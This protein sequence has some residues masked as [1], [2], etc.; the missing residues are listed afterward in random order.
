MKKSIALL[1][2]LVMLLATCG[3]AFASSGQMLGTEV[4][5]EGQAVALKIAKR[6]TFL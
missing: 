5:A 4:L 1:L 3:T 6:A 2:A